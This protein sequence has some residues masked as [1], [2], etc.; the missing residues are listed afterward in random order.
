MPQL[1]GLSEQTWLYL[2]QFGILFGDLMLLV[3]IP[4]GLLAFFKRDAI[5][6]WLWRNRFPKVGDLDGSQK[7]WDALLFTVSNPI[8]PEWVIDCVEPDTV[9]LLATSRSMEAA[10]TIM[11]YAA[12]RGINVLPIEL[13][14]DP[15]NPAE[16]RRR[17]KILLDELRSAGAERIAVDITGGKTPMSVGAFMAAEERG[18]T[19]LY[20]TAPHGD[21][22][23]NTAKARI[24]A[25]STPAR[26]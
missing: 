10:R 8:L 3:A 2:D 4:G 24:R 23:L 7:D 22:G 20:V 12:E 11:T 18:A 1:F 25:I 5:R 16:T 14:S 26:R 21:D 13:L 19:S 15:D 9:A 6:R 17:C